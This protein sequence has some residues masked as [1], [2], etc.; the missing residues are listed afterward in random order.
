MREFT[1]KPF[2]LI[3]LISAHPSRQEWAL[4]TLESTGLGSSPACAAHPLPAPGKV[5]QPQ[6]S[7]SSN[8]SLDTRPYEGRTSCELDEL[9]YMS[10][11]M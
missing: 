4:V 10:H 1:E 11:L 5:P 2:M 7:F 9:A 6:D 8:V 3:E